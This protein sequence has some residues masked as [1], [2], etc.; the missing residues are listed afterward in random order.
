MTSR[1]RSQYREVSRHIIVLLAGWKEY[2]QTSSDKFGAKLWCV[3]S[4]YAQNNENSLVDRK[5]LKRNWCLRVTYISRKISENGSQH[6]QYWAASWTALCFLLLRNNYFSRAR[7]V[8]ADV[9]VWLRMIDEMWANYVNFRLSKCT[10][11]GAD[12]DCVWSFSVDTEENKQK[13]SSVLQ[14]FQVGSQEIYWNSEIILALRFG[15]FP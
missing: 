2:W 4:N 3:L 14:L 12:A 8:S 11:S 6:I 9:S 7:S 1:S 10:V 15:R 5:I 13:L